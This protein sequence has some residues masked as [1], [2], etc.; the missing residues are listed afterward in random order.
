[1]NANVVAHL[2][3]DNVQHLVKVGL[4]MMVERLA[5]TSDDQDLRVSWTGPIGVTYVL[6][7]TV[8]KGDD[9]SHYSI[10]LLRNGSSVSDVEF[11][12]PGA[13]GMPDANSM[14]QV[15]LSVVQ[16]KTS[17][18]PQ[19]IT[20][21]SARLTYR[22]G[23]E[24]L[25][26]SGKSAS[27]LRRQIRQYVSAE[28]NRFSSIQLRSRDLGAH[29]VYREAAHQWTSVPY[30]GVQDGFT[31]RI[32]SRFNVEAPTREHLY[33]YMARVARRAPSKPRGMADVR[34]LWRGVH[35][36]QAE[37]LLE[38]GRLEGA[39]FIAT[40]HDRRVAES[41]AIARAGRRASALMCL[42]IN[43]IPRGTP[44]IWFNHDVPAM[45]N[46]SE[47]LLPPGSLQVVS[48]ERE[49]FVVRYAPS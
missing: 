14:Q 13:N 30:Q 7:A 44:W 43:T 37:R 39:G 35:G 34:V 11:R 17:T 31:R 1:M 40:S 29:R 48:D 45:A 6:I 38:T 3:H 27:Q 22:L 23:Q 12:W 26:L 32:P 18:S 47:V 21:D 28:R 33:A 24:T 15:A 5:Y 19:T 20:V 8:N 41:F 16:Q 2:S 9:Y 25:Q 46:E 49:F 10:R 4:E 36:R 42:P